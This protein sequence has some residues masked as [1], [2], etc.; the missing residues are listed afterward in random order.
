MIAKVLLNQTVSRCSWR[1][2]RQYCTSKLYFAMVKYIHKVHI[3][4][5]ILTYVHFCFRWN[6]YFKVFPF[7]I[8]KHPILIL[9]WMT[10]WLKLKIFLL[11]Q[12]TSFLYIF[13]KLNTHLLKWLCDQNTIQNITAST[14][15]DNFI[16]TKKS[17]CNNSYG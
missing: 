9:K 3:S 2:P 17:C 1:I 11:N 8:V 5:G 12:N 4:I 7:L 16:Y 14:F 15:K 10:V 6:N 13:Y